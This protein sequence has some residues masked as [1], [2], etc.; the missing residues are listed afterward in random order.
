MNFESN[1]M[2]F[3]QP[4]DPYQGP[5]YIELANDNMEKNVYDHLYNMTTRK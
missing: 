5:R 4:L 2:N 3:T 1:D